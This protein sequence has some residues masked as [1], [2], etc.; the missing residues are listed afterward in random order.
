LTIELH[1][2]LFEDFYIKNTKAFI[3]LGFESRVYQK[4]VRVLD[5]VVKT[6]TPNHFLI[7]VICHHAKHFIA[8]GITLRHL[9]DI[10]LYVNEYYNQLDWEFIM[11]SLEQFRI[12]DFTIHL[13]Y[14]CQHYLG[15]VNLSF[16]Y[17]EIDEDVIGML[18]YDIVERN[19]TNSNNAL[20]SM[21]AR[22]IVRNIYYGSGKPSAIKYSLFP[23]ATVLK[24][25]YIYARKHPV[26]LPVAWVHRAF[27]YLLRKLKGQKIL[28]PAERAKIAKERIELLRR[29]QIL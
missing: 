26:L 20:N 24:K 16:L 17:Q 2:R 12:K 10:C 29:V 6:F 15:M 11:A 27:S 22:E 8:T 19:A 18:I 9:I 7:Y 5:T 21:S 28:S 13:L 4:Q 25:K 23:S 3:A 14:I 1:L